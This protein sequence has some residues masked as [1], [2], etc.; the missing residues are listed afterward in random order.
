MLAETVQRGFCQPDALSNELALGSDR[1]SALP[2]RIL[3]EISG[4]ARSAAEGTAWRLWKR[5]RLPQCEWNVEILS[6]DGR[7]IA[8][9]DAW[10]DEVAL[11]WEIDSKEFHFTA[12][13]YAATLSRNNRYAAAGVVLVQTLPSLLRSDP[14]R[15]IR[16]LKAAYAVASM[17]P[18]PAI[19]FR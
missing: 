5:A 1:G 9:P 13:G 17:R 11:A 14:A 16:E 4:G 19:T 2:R 18:R 15:V 12:D 3:A 6:A 10:C 8:R 7:R